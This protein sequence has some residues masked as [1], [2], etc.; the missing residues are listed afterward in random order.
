LEKFLEVQKEEKIKA[1][2]LA[3]GSPAPPGKGSG[4]TVEGHPRDNQASERE[5][6]LKQLGFGAVAVL[7]VIALIWRPWEP[8]PDKPKPIVENN[9]AEYSEAA[10]SSTVTL[11]PLAR[12]R[13]ARKV[14]AASVIKVDGIAVLGMDS[15]NKKTKQS[16]NTVSLNICFNTTVNEIAAPGNELFLIRI[17]LPS[18][19]TMAMDNLGSGVFVNNASGEHVRYTR[20]KETSYSN[21]VGKVCADWNP[22]QAFAEGQYKVEVY[23]KGYLAGSTSFSLN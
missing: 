10:G 22:G 9:D 7:L 2:K 18:G 4:G 15:K 12:E 23:N 8:I 5:K 19:E 20:S 14:N 1:E 13:L 21:S 3:A 6:T 16:K 11:E 17:I